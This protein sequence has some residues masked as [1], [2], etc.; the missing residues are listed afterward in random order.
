MKAIYLVNLVCG[1][2]H[3]F[4]VA[5]NEIRVLLSHYLQI[6]ICHVIRGRNWCASYFSEDGCSTS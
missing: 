6:T 4:M 2:S 1:S 5:I 3:A